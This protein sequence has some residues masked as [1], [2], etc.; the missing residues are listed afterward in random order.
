HDIILYGYLMVT[1]VTDIRLV[2]QSLDQHVFLAIVGIKEIIAEVG[3]LINYR[4]HDIFPL[5]IDQSKS[6]GFFRKDDI[7]G[8]ARQVLVSIVGF[9]RKGKVIVVGTAGDDLAV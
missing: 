5:P 3:N 4:F 9:V 2:G 8:N 7:L 1:G 6:S